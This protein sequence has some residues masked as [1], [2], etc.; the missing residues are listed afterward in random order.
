M[1]VSVCSNQNPISPTEFKS[2]KINMVCTAR[3]GTHNNKNVCR[4]VDRHVF[5]ASGYLRKTCLVL[6]LPVA[7]FI[8]A[9]V[10]FGE[11]LLM[12]FF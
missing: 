9:M 8:V 7:S 10:L 11:P 12:L 1:Y 3:K 4:Q 6:V 2:I 5:T